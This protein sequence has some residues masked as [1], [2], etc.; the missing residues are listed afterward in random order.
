MSIGI[1]TT[2]RVTHWGMGVSHWLEHSSPD[3]PDD[4]TLI[5]AREFVWD[6][7]GDDAVQ[8]LAEKALESIGYRPLGWWLFTTPED[9]YYPNEPYWHS[10]VE[11]IPGS[12]RSWRD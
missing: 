11:R 2:A 7:D 5:W 12:T 10:V 6:E 9:D 4:R 1:I 8:E 3:S